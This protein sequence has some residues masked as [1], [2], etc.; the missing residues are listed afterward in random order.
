[1]EFLLWIPSQN[2]FTTYHASSKTAR[3]EAQKMEPLIGKAITLRCKLI[4]PPKSRFKWHGPVVTGCSTPLETPSVEDM[5]AE[6]VKFQNPQESV[7]EV[8]DEDE[9]GRER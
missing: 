3:R 8:A 9:S 1:P 5:Q 7:V 2:L 6:V 4:D